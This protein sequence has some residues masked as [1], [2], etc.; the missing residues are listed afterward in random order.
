[1]LIVSFFEKHD[2]LKQTFMLIENKLNTIT[3]LYILIY[4]HNID[5]QRWNSIKEY[6]HKIYLIHIYITNIQN[7][8]TLRKFS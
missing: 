1:M 7:N 8:Y 2:I 4:I 3:T 5:K 6:P